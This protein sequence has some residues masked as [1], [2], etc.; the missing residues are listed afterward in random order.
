MNP[1]EPKL[2]PGGQLMIFAKDQEPYTPLPASVDSVGSVITEW[3]FTAEELQ[4]IMT[5]GRIRL[6]ILFT[7]VH[8]GVPLSPIKIEVVEPEC[9]FS[10]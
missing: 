1:V 7:S 4:Q 8:N 2:H 6:Y 10:G 5:G 9:G 3:E